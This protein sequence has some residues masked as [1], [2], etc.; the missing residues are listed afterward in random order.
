MY[1]RPHEKLIA[2]QRAYQLCL[3][4]YK[5]TKDFP[6]SEKFALVNQMRR[7]SSSTPINIAEGNS[8][9]TKKERARFWEIAHS[10]LEE[11]HCEC[12]LAYDL[13]YITPEKFDGLNGE[14]NRVSYLLGKLRASLQ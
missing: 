8:R 10:S 9:H 3:I 5:A 6:E 14:I 11:L 12:R 2:W 4:I 1:Q 7:A 13:G